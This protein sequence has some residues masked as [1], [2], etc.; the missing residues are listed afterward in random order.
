MHASTVCKGPRPALQVEPSF[1]C[2]G[3]RIIVESWPPLF[4]VLGAWF[5]EDGLLEC[6]NK[7]LWSSVAA[8][9]VACCAT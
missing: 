8:W 9:T 5:E 4:I 6:A 7:V 2:P 3:I 1:A